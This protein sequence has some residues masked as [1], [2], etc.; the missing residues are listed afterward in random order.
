[1]S[2]DSSERVFTQAVKPLLDHTLQGN[3]STIL[4]FGPTGSGKTFTMSAIASLTGTW[5]DQSSK[6]GG[7]G[8]MCFEVSA[9]GVRD[10]IGNKLV[11]VRDCGNGVEFVDATCQDVMSGNDLVEAIQSKP[12][13]PLV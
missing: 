10:L 1:M 12:F 3:R 8:L 4:M 7:L 9:T 6:G 2:F 5:F 13:H 11:D